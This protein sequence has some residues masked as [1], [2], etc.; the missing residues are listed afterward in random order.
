MASKSGSHKSDD[1][2]RHSPVTRE[3]ARPV[4]AQPE[5]TENPKHFRIKHAS[6]A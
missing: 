5:P 6:D 1:E 4:F 3:P 2:S